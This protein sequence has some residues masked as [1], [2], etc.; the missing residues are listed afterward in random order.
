MVATPDEVRLDPIEDALDDQVV[1]R[2]VHPSELDADQVKLQQV[3]EYH[4]HKAGD[5]QKDL[6][7]EDSSRNDVEPWRLAEQ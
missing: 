5:S 1:Q 3:E 7:L 2:E 6:E 4:R